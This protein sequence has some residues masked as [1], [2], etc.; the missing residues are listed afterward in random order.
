MIDF[1]YVG[2]SLP[3]LEGPDKITGHSLYVADIH[4]PNMLHGKI[5]H[6]PLSHAHILHIDTSK[7]LSHPGVKAVITAADTIGA[8]AGRWYKD[9]PILAHSKVHYIGEPVAALAAVD[10]ETALEALDLI[11]VEYEELPAVFDPVLAM[12]P[13]SPLVHED[14]DTFTPLPPQRQGQG[15]ILDQMAI[16]HGNAEKALENSY[17]IHHDIYRTRPV[18]SSYIEPQVVLTE[19][20][21]S[22][23]ATLWASTKQVHVIRAETARLLGLP[24]SKVR[25]IAPTVGGDFGGKGA[26]VLQPLC[27]LLALKAQLP[28]RMV[29]SREEEF[30]CTFMREAQIIDLT[31]GVRRDGTILAIKGQMLSDTGAYCDTNA[32]ISIET[33]CGSYHCADIDL[34]AY[35][36]YTNNT[37]RGQ[38][39]RTRASGQIFA[40]ES[41]M[42]ML[43]HKLGMDPLALRLKNAMTEGYKFPDSSNYLGS[44]GLKEALLT[45]DEYLKKEKRLGEKNRGWGLVC[46]LAGASGWQPPSKFSSAWVKIN[47]DGSAVL[48]TGVTDQGGGQYGIMAQIVAEILSIPY[49]S[50]KV[51]AADTDSTP[52]EGTTGG[53]QTTYRVG[54]SVKL[55]AEDARSKILQRAS[56]KLESPPEALELKDGKIFIRERPERSISLSA[57]A[58]ESL[59][60]PAFP[61]GPIIGTGEQLRENN[62]VSR[63]ERKGEIDGSS[64]SVHIAQVEVDPETGSVK[65]LKYFA[66]HDAGCAI[67]PENVNSQI[68][69]AVAFGLGYALSEEVKLEQ[70]R[71]LNNNF[72]DYK[73]PTINTVPIVEKAIIE[74]PSKFGPYGARG[75]AEM[76]TIVVAPTIANA[77]YDAVGVRITELPIT[78]ERVFFA[79]K[80]KGSSQESSS[81][82][83]IP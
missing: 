59:F 72:T 53:S 7:A 49:E 57:L 83:Q 47:E 22:G 73:L 20:D 41:H 3:R 8:R 76:P 67:N 27:L 23:K 5:L 1:T 74:V 46:D 15:N 33:L 14:A 60:S 2:K 56:V 79:L 51:L 78:G 26:I 6:S 58:A 37:P 17:L 38:V 44:N 77:I 9:R 50:V 31:M 63:M 10:E 24:L 13:E 80:D 54:S 65:I 71:T 55:A 48:I 75:M 70:G 40:R 35:L 18:H 52:Y 62:I 29:L 45:A 64:A 69:G 39:R 36:V 43:A 42:D 61:G 4:S 81:S 11:R 12:R 34:K 66:V 30:I 19:V 32:R 21:A 25:V 28:V 68:Q 16:I 82:N